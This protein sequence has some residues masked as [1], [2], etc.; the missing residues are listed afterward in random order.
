MSHRI[1]FSLFVVGFAVAVGIGYGFKTAVLSKNTSCLP[2]L[3]VNLPDVT[4]EAPAEAG[5]RNDVPKLSFSDSKDHSIADEPVN[6]SDMAY[7]IIAKGDS[8]SGDQNLIILKR[9]APP[10]P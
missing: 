6:K 7:Q 10:T 1:R 4:R 8:V 2:T 9:I 3:V 5:S